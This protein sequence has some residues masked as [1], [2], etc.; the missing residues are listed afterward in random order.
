MGVLPAFRRRGHGLE[1]VHEAPRLLTEAR[2][3][4]IF[5]DTGTDNAPMVNAFRRAG[6]LGRQ[7]WQWP[8]A[9][10]TPDTR[11]GPCLR[12]VL[13]RP[14]TQRVFATQRLARRWH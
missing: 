13:A 6:Y 4:R 3:W 1:L 10:W 12:R 11:L 5:C 14:A 2:C 8:L 7:P 9:H